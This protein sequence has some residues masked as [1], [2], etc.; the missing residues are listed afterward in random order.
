MNDTHNGNDVVCTE[1]RLILH[2]LPALRVYRLGIHRFARKSQIYDV[3]ASVIH[4][5][6]SKSDHFPT[7]RQNDFLPAQ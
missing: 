3:Q 5:N 6:S 4:K 7:R 1:T 2:R